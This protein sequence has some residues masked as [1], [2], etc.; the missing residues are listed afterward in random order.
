MTPLDPRYLVVLDGKTS[1]AYSDGMEPDGPWTHEF[2][3]SD[4]EVYQ[5][6]RVM[7]H[8]FRYLESHELLDDSGYEL[9][10]HP[11]SYFVDEWAVDFILNMDDLSGPT[12]NEIRSGIAD[13]ARPIV[14]GRC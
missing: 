10:A 6:S 5:A 9:Q 2:F 1:G 3:G 7:C 4:G 14:R 8:G 12:G 11:L 13:V